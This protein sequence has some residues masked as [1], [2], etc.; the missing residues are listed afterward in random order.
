M[1]S[2][3]DLNGRASYV[4]WH[5]FLMSVPNLVVVALMLIVFA[6]ALYLRAPGARRPKDDK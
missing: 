4:H 1:G 6:L 3:V 5:F 2:I